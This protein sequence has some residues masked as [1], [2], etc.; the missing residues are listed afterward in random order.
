ML[1]L[2]SASKPDYWK[3]KIRRFSGVIW[4]MSTVMTVRECLTYSV[5]LLI[6]LTHISLIALDLE[7]KKE[8]ISG[9]ISVKVPSMPTKRN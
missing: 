2:E 3:L 9:S 7:V 5:A 8:R 1:S 4:I 6:H